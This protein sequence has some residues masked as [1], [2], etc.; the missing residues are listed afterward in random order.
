MKI[1]DEARTAAED[2]I[3]SQHPNAG[4]DNED[5]GIRIFIEQIAMGGQDD[6]SLVQ[7]MQSLINSTFDRAVAVV[8]DAP[9]SLDNNDQIAA[10]ILALKEDTQ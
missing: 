3:S 8:A 9:V 10:A 1:S 4:W 2:Y 5:R 6:H 7:A